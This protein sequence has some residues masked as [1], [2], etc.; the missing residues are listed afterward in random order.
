MTFPELV[1]V[2]AAG[3][4]AVNA[5]FGASV[6]LRWLDSTRFRWVHHGLYIATFLLTVA[7]ISSVL[8]SS[9]RAGWYLL[10][11]VVPLAVLPY[12]G[13]AHKHPGRHIVVALGALPFYILGLAVAF[14]V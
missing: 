13:S 9:S 8:W 4:Y 2:L 10:P 12:A 11:A 3:A 6:R 5:A 1:L 14:S 7:A